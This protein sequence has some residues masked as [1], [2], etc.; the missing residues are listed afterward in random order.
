MVLEVGAKGN[1]VQRLQMLLND[2]L[3]PS[4]KL[5]VDGH[6]G[7][8][9]EAAVIEFQTRKKLEVDGVVGAQTWAALG[10]RATQTTMP[11]VVSAIGA[12]WYDKALLEVGVIAN[13]DKKVNTQRIV[14]YHQTTTLKAKSDNTAWCA[15]FVNWC[16]IQGGKTGCNSAAAIDWLNYGQKLDVPRVGAITVIQNPEMKK[17]YDASTGTASG[18][19]VSFFVRKSSAYITLFGGNQTHQVKESNYPLASWNVLGYRWPIG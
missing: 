2:A 5:N 18:N 11:E 16:L 15:A 19:H 10:Q 6:F 14:D 9:T 8:R 3:R 13:L 7:A 4:M 1:A 12:P 17:K